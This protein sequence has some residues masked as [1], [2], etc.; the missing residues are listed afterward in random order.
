VSENDINGLT[1]QNEKTTFPVSGTLLDHALVNYRDNVFK[2][3]T[4]SFTLSDH[5]PIYVSLKS[6]AIKLQSKGHK[7]ML[8]RSK[9]NFSVDTFLDDLE[10]LP[11]STMDMFSEP[12]EALSHWYS[13][14][15]VYWIHTLL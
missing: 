11:W 12:N 15:R 14:L 1:S 5:L 8:F 10:C 3:G 9:K 6:R 13:F 2:S 4:L 7:P